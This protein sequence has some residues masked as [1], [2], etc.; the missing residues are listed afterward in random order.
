MSEQEPSPHLETSQESVPASTPE[1]SEPQS[2]YTPRLPNPFWGPGGLRTGWSVLLFFLVTLVILFGVGS[3][4]KAVLRGLID[5]KKDGNV[6]I[7]ASIGQTIEVIGVFGAA[8]I[9]ARVERRRVTDYNL[10]GSRRLQHFAVGL[11]A[12]FAALSALV[13]AMAAGGWLRFGPVAAVTG[14]VLQAA[15]LW[16]IAMLL[17][18]LGEEGAVRCY[19]LFTLTRGIDLWWAIGLQA[20]MCLSCIFFVHNEGKWGVYAMTA[21][22]LGP[23]LWLHMRKS[24]ASGFWQA[25][26]VT[27]TFF[28]FIHTGNNGENWIGIFGAAAIGFVFCVSVRLTGSAWW[29]IGFHSAWNWA[30]TFFYGTSDSGMAAKGHFLTTTP[31]G[32]TLL[33]GGTDGPEGSLLIVPLIALALIAVIL[34]YGRRGESPSPD[35]L[36]RLS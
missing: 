5:F 18:G 8:W 35:G 25:A 14:A 20:A 29:A 17:T 13:G 24:Q 31:T 1:P 9:C 19:L 30:E 12:G 2:V 32:S 6:P 28:G 26:W 11:L 27:S 10:G 3:G 7:L 15:V 16:A 21:L 23:V 36:T 34:V 22:G 33:S 4:A